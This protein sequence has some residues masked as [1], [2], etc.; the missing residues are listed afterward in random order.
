MN[1]TTWAN[2]LKNAVLYASLM[3]LTSVFSDV[4]AQSISGA[5]GVALAQSVTAL[6][7][8]TWSVFQNPAMMP[9][10]GT[11]ISFYAIR[12]YGLSEL[13]DSALAGIYNA[14]FG[15][16][17]VGL[18]SYGYELYKE[19]QLRFAITKSFKNF[20]IGSTIRYHNISIKNY[21]SAG[22]IAFDT[23]FAMMLAEGLWLGVYAGNISR[24]TLGEAHEELPV[25]FAIGLSYTLSDRVLVVSDLFKDVRFPFS[26]RAGTEVT[27]LDDILQLR[28]GI[29]TEPITYSIGIGL[30]RAYWSVDIAAQHHEWLGWSP[31]IGLNSAW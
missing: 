3:I 31:G 17:S 5:K 25:E 21:G 4:N 22:T 29:S 23:G 7:D 2:K 11:R 30:E 8:N 10:K 14:S 12:Y 16:L 24:S 27:I 1:I 15:T 19:S 18:H 28:T 13:T 9:R 20:R 6:Q 26:Y